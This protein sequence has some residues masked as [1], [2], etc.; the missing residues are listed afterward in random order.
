MFVQARFHENYLEFREQDREFQAPGGLTQSREDIG[1]S[2]TL[3]SRTLKDIV[4]FKLL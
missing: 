4:K 1:H 3:L 2:A